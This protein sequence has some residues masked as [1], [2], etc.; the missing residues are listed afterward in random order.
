MSL[1]KEERDW[2][3]NPK[4]N[5][6]TFILAQP[7]SGAEMLA[8]ILSKL[9]SKVAVCDELDFFQ[10]L[11]NI[12]EHYEAC[13]LYAQK[14][15]RWQEID[16]NGTRYCLRNIL[17]KGAD[18][19]F[20]TTTSVGWRNNMVDE[21]VSSLRDMHSNSV[22]G[23]F[24]LVFLTRDSKDACNEMSGSFISMF[25]EQKAQFKNCFELGDMWL[26]Y[27]GFMNDI[28]GT[29]IKL[30]PIDYPDMYRIKEAMK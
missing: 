25:D 14:Y 30:R 28:Q 13:K 1:S 7:R 26:T 27:E 6:Y 18:S 11:I 17:Y 19:G 8:K 9:G 20:A 24:R 10:G 21:F 12:N 5:G 23:P 22:S 29:I 15:E 4:R 2:I 3:N 16:Q